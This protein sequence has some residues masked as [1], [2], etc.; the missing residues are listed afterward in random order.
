ME[1]RECKR[2][3]TWEV[4]ADVEGSAASSCFGSWVVVWGVHISEL[5]VRVHAHMCH[6]TAQ[7]VRCWKEHLPLSFGQWMAVE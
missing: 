1:Y 2:V 6:W 7:L 3:L 5:C 4:R